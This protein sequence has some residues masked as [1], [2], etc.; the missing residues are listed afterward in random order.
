MRR[1][2]TSNAIYDLYK[3]YKYLC[4]ET[5]LS[6][7]DFMLSV[8]EIVFYRPHIFRKYNKNKNFILISFNTVQ[9]QT[10]DHHA[11]LL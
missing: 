7:K 10:A 5:F 8:F 4:T 1:D 9:S 11:V 3:L 6:V 2:F